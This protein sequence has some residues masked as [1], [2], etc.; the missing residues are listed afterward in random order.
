MPEDL[1]DF[2][3]ILQQELPHVG[4]LFQDYDF[5][6]YKELVPMQ[7]GDVLLTYVDTMH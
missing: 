2:V 3:D 5:E 6:D 4:V 7:P 1:L